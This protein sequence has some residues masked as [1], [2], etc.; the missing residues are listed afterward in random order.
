MNIYEVELNELTPEVFAELKSKNLITIP[1]NS[2]G[3]SFDYTM[4][5]SSESPIQI[6]EKYGHENIKGI[7]F[8]SKLL[9]IN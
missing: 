5:I 6:Y 4:Y 8:F 3:L 1:E 7:R 9:I 2:F